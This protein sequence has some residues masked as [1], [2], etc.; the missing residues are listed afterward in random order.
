MTLP[1]GAAPAPREIGRVSPSLA[2]SLLGCPLETAFQLDPT[3]SEFNRPSP[4]S[5][6]GLASHEMVEQVGQGRFDEPE[7]GELEAA[8]ERGFDAA[9]EEQGKALAEAWPRSS[10]P[11]PARWPGY[12]PTRR[13]LLRRLREQALGRRR[14]GH[15][16]AE[17]RVEEMIRASD[18]PVH[19]RPDRVEVRPDGVHLVD[20]KSGW[21]A[22]PDLRPA[23]RR[24]LLIYAFLWHSRHGVWPVTASVQRLDGTRLSFNVDS[25]EAERLVADLLERR[26]E[27]NRTEAAD[28][29]DLAF[30]SPETCEHCPFRATCSPFFESVDAEWGLYRRCV[31]GSVVS[32]EEWAE[33]G[34]LR[35]GVE[36]GNLAAEVTEARL[37]SIPLGLGLRDGEVVSVVDALPSRVPDEIRMAWD[38]IVFSWTRRMLLT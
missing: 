4:A 27:F 38:T 1:Q 7:E 22:M 37:V 13:R 33:V 35:L 2:E 30:P 20:L 6:L 19:G 34:A 3:Y 12:R 10:I 31:V 21:A 23:H 5:A 24:Q 29:W 15:P 26:E 11:E 32:V 16:K 17:V 14:G 8:L 25:A 28:T 9:I 18:A 36:G